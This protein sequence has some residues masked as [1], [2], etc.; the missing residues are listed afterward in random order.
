[1]RRAGEFRG[2]N[3]ADRDKRILERPTYSDYATT[4]V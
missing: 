3:G 4:K 2:V 1:V